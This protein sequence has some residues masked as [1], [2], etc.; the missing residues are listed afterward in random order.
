MRRISRISEQAVLLQD[1]ISTLRAAFRTIRAAIG[2][3]TTNTNCL[4]LGALFCQR[5][6]WYRGTLT[7]AASVWSD[8]SPGEEDTITDTTAALASS[9]NGTTGG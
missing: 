8:S 6:H 9:R 2:H 5:E 4:R 1:I 3:D 7:Y